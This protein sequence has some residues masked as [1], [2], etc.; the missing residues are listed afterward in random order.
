MNKKNKW[1]DFNQVPPQ[2]VEYEEVVLAACIMEQDAVDKCALIIE[3]SDYFYSSRHKIIWE[4]MLEMSQ[5]LIPIDLLTISQELEK[6]KVLESIGGHFYI[7]Q[8]TN[9]IARISSLEF[10]CLEIKGRYVLRLGLKFAN[11]L[12][13]NIFDQPSMEEYLSLIQ[14]FTLQSSDFINGAAKKASSVKDLT[15]Q[16]LDQLKERVHKFTLNEITG[17][18]TGS[19]QLDDHT[20]GWQKTDLIV[21]A[22]RPSM[23]KTAFALFLARAAAMAQ[24]EILIFSLEMSAV[25]LTDRLIISESNVEAWRYRTGQL[26][27]TDH[28]RVMQAANTVGRMPIEID[29]KAGATVEYIRSRAILKKSKGKLSGIIID[30]LQLM[31][32]AGNAK[33]M[34]R[35]TEISKQTNNLKA[36]AKE[37]E[38]PII[39]LCQLNR[40]VEHRTG[41]AKR[42]MLADLRESGAIEQDADI[43]ILLHRP[44]R[45]GITEDADGNS[46]I[47][48]TEVDFAKY[49]DG[50]V[51]TFEL[52]H[53]KSLSRYWDPDSTDKDAQ[54]G[55]D[56]DKVEEFNAVIGQQDAGL[57]RFTEDLPPF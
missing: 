25:K 47:G 18:T 11:D 26:L 33:N 31:K 9:R 30:Y 49:R 16:A 14:G 3:N 37:L 48:I 55:I 23:G 53:N 4:T 34:T 22:A 8:L 20:N 38:V 45:Y 1:P 56:F 17:I 2:V 12:T 24:E 7:S 40:K 57:D 50:A 21:I 35:D 41:D 36:L 5:K 43:V 13:K 27:A 10:Y 29:D 39:L 15:S 52:R 6:K 44:E 19:K 28:E 54:T 32:S 51:G 46:L 42:P